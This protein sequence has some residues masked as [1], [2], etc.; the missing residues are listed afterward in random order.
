MN[1]RLKPGFRQVSNSGDP[2]WTWVVK[3]A[4]HQPAAVKHVSPADADH[5]QEERWEREETEE[6]IH[7]ASP[8][9]PVVVEEPDPVEDLAPV[10]AVAV[11][12]EVIAVP[13]VTEAPRLVEDETAERHAGEPEQQAAKRTPLLQ[14]VRVGGTVRYV[15]RYPGSR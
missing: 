14:S 13:H 9:E 6:I 3:S 12:P 8:A 5:K 1:W 4:Q 10:A 15:K 11:E 2:R 7:A